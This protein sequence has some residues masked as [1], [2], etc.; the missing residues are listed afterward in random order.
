MEGGSARRDCCLH[1][2]EEHDLG[3]QLFA[4]R[5][6]QQLAHEDTLSDTV[7]GAGEALAF[8]LFNEPFQPILNRDSVAAKAGTMGAVECPV[9]R[10]RVFGVGRPR[11][12]SATS[13]GWGS[14]RRGAPDAVE[15]PLGRRAES[16]I[17]GG[18]DEGN[19][20]VGY[21]LLSLSGAQEVHQQV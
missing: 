17:A 13:W 4:E 1:L 12:N 8:Q 20:F 14:R 10:E 18:W 9:F 3:A 7:V 2:G 21:W 19:A 15:G 11:G 5:A 16:S 6:S